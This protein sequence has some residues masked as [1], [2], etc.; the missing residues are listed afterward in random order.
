MDVM[1][2]HP[3]LLLMVFAILLILAFACG[4]IASILAEIFPSTKII[5]STILL[6]LYFASAVM[7]PL[8]IVPAQYIGI[9]LYNPVLHLVELFRYYFFPYYPMTDGINI[10]YP[11]FF[12]LVALFVALYFYRVRRFELA[13]KS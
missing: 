4:I 7:F 5:V 8:W 12:T 11:L 3:F 6:V 10:Y 1:P 13:A 9:L 2:S